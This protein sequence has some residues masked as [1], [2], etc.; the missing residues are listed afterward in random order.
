M[1]FKPTLAPYV[2]YGTRVSQ[3]IKSVI[4]LSVDLSIFRRFFFLHRQIDRFEICRH[5]DISTDLTFFDMST[6]FKSV[7]PLCT[8]KL[9]SSLFYLLLT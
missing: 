5:V 8:Y 7:D 6:D 3:K 9:K 1:L 2:P 4:C